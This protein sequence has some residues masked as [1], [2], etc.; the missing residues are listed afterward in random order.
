MQSKRAR[1]DRF[2]SARTGIKRGE[3]KRLLASG[4]I[5]IDGKPAD[6]VQQLID[7][8]TR[9]SLDHCVLQDNTAVYL[10]MNKPS[11]VV[12]ATSDKR[13]K[14]VVDC[15][16]ASTG[17]FERNALH[18]AGRLDYNSTGLILLTNDGR[19]SRRLSAPQSQVAK[20]YQVT[21]ANPV[22][23]ECADQYVSAFASG[24]YFPY[25]DISTQA[26]KLHIL[27]QFTAEVHL[28]EGRYHQIKR[29]FGRFQNP[30]LTLHRS[31]IGRIQ[32]DPALAPGASRSLT[33]SEVKSFDPQGEMAWA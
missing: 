31:A 25:E 23:S 22:T 21:L 1:L 18:I 16:H 4:R 13:H 20:V 10:M 15:L 9:V 29:M 26:A 24:M 8:F 28:L 7:Q 27:D 32:L 12:S 5:D 3:V 19:W 30:V 2:I 17:E 6:S 14:T 33:E 11:G